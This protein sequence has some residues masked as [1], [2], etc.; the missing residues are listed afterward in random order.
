M[1]APTSSRRSRH[2][3]LSLLLL[4]LNT[5]HQPTSK[6][7]PNLQSPSA[8]HD[9]PCHQHQAAHIHSD[10]T[11]STCHPPTPPPNGMHQIHHKPI[12]PPATNNQS[13]S[14]ASL[15]VFVF[16]PFPFQ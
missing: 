2:Q 15:S 11:P 5:H 4:L 10:P 16:I 9:P 14:I 6:S 12:V 7:N 13:P 1:N 3:A 8:C